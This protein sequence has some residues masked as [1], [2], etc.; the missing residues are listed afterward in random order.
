MPVYFVFPNNQSCRRSR[1]F[2]VHTHFIFRVHQNE[3]FLAFC[4][5]G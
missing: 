5:I 3:F 2:I 1:S 4:S